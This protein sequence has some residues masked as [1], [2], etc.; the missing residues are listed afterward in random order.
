M[1]KLIREGSAK[2]PWI[3]K[4]IVILIALTFMIGMGWFGY[5]NAQQPNAVAIVGPHSVS[6]DEFRRAYTRMFRFY[7]DEMK[8]EVVDEA[9]LKQKVIQGMV[10]RKVWLVTA[11]EWEIDIPPETL[12]EE[13]VKKK[14]FQKDGVFD[15]GLYHRLLTANRYTPKQF[16]KQM[17]RDLI[18]QHA[19][20]IAQDVAT[21]NPSEMQEAKE[22]A[23]RQTA[24]MEDEAEIERVR[25]RIKLQ[26]LFQKKQRA[27]QAFQTAKRMASDVT[28]REEYL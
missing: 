11:D 7:K 26:I 20:I 21:L 8:Q 1:I 14:E 3:L 23:E 6:L 19:Q 24:G 9:D 17:T 4:I 5:D 10:D 2:Y 18:S 15:A 16:E 22:L 27:L 13:I 28:I 12:R 25:L